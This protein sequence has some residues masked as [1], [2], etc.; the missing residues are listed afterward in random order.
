VLTRAECPWASHADSDAKSVTREDFDI[1]LGTALADVAHDDASETEESLSS[2]D[3]DYTI[4]HELLGTLVQVNPDGAQSKRSTDNVTV[5]EDLV[6]GV[7]DRRWRLDQKEDECDSALR[8]L[9]AKVGLVEVGTLTMK[10]DMM[11][12]LP[13]MDA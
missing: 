3:C 13:V 9:L 1:S 4:Q 8:Y 2:P 10:P 12:V 6:E 7:T 11:N 5:Q